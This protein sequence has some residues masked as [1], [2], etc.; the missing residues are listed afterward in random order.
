MQWW[1]ELSF[2]IHLENSSNM[3][4][5]NPGHKKGHDVDSESDQVR[6]KEMNRKM[7]VDLAQIIFVQC[8]HL[9]EG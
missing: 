8:S 4:F 9:G 2:Y 7:K 6:R 1:Y 5:S 3:R